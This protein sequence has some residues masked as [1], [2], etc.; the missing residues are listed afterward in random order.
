MKRSFIPL[1]LLLLCVGCQTVSPPPPPPPPVAA[2]PAP[3]LTRVDILSQQA[4]TLPAAQVTATAGSLTIAYPQESLFST[5]SVL[6]LAGGA[7]ALDPLAAL[8]VAYPEAIWDAKVRAATTNGADYDLTLAQ[9][10]RDLLQRYLR[11]AGVAND[12]VIWQASSGDGIPLELTLRPLQPL[13]GS[14]PGVKE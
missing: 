13:A 9:K 1:F 12:R 5:G 14:S 3:L 8:L 4:A 11:H 7:E 2:P 6:P 10:R